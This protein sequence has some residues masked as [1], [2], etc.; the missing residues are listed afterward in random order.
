MTVKQGFVA[1]S[2]VVSLIIIGIGQFWSP[3]YW[4]FIVVIPLILLGIYDIIQKKHTL[5]RLYPVIGHGRYI[6][7]SIRPEIQQYFV[8]SDINGTPINREFRSLVYQRA[9]G[10][11]D[12]RPFGTQFDVYRSGYEWVNHSL[13]PKA[14]ANHHPRII[15][16]GPQCKH[17]YAAS[18]LNISAMSFGALSKNAIS[19][20]NIAAKQGAFSH[21]TGEGGISPYHLSG[22]ADLVWQI[23]T[24]Y[25][26]CRNE[27]GYFDADKFSDK[28]A[29]DVV[30]MIEIKLSQGA[31]PGHGGIL[32]A[33]K[34]TQEIADIRHVP[35]GQDVVSPPA[36]SAF[37]NPVGL[38]G[39][40]EKL[41]E[42]SG[43]KP[44]GFKL[45]IGN[46]VEFLA[47]VKA[48]VE[49]GITP[50]FITVDGGEGGTGAA[51][52]ELTNSVGM[53]LRDALIFVNNALIGSGLREH[54]R[55]IASGKALSAFHMLR[56]MALGADTINSA[57]AMMLA[58]GCVQSRSCNTDRC[59]TGV[60]TQNPARF[61][62]LDIK[63][64][65]KRVA[66]Y[67]A[68]MIE[69]LVELIAV[70]GL[71]SL[72]QLEPQHINRRVSGTIVKNYSELYPSISCDCL[73]TDSEIPPMW[74]TLWKQ[75]SAAA[76]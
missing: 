49:T 51:P 34:V 52:I 65:S 45:C 50:D 57:R 21:N 19:A 14:V 70:A 36:H 61:K 22:G 40:V 41:R 47:I 46:T 75:A 63:Q 69:H 13:N 56:L 15:F 66:N 1:I 11:N 29:Y 60:A 39:F 31:K 27:H 4:S 58:L 12:T 38:L 3:V 28:A 48:M 73:L 7:E 30:K 72:D 68:A 37:D 2:I 23:G 44:V 24:G 67:H 62:A 35:M 6:F 54:I 76:W 64:K 59:P 26:G 18:P 42:L 71:E 16:G 53:P 8:E 9:K 32:P 74:Q 17:P 10:H 25:F 20:L 33:A 55:I 5:L 43:R